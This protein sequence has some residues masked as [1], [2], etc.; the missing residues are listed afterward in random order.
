[1][2]TDNTTANTNLG[3][4]ARRK[5]TQS[6]ANDGNGAS[7]GINVIS[8]L[9]R[10]SSFE[11]LE[12]KMLVPMQLQFNIELQ[13]DNELIHMANGTDDERVVVNRKEREYIRMNIWILLK[14]L[15]KLN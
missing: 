10:Y 7:E 1:M 4:A 6:V 9:N 3:F 15:K 13:N 2:D 11:E 14:S 5:L 12:D 8:P